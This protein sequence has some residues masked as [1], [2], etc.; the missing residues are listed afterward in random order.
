MTLE[1]PRNDMV[2]G[3]KVTDLVRVRINVQQYGM[4]SNSMNIYLFIQFVQI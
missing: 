1:Y 2:L 4:C 3:F